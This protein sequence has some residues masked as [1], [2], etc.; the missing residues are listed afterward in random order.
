VLIIF[1]V[2]IIGILLASAPIV[3]A[4]VM[5]LMETLPR[6][7]DTTLP[8]A[9]K[10]L[11]DSKVLANSQEII[12]NL[13]NRV[14]GWVSGALGSIVAGSLAFFN[15]VSFIVVTP[16]V[17]FYLL[18]DWPLIVARVESWW[19]R[20]QLPAIKALWVESDAALSGF[21][22]GQSLVCLALAFFYAVGWSLVGLD[23]A[24]VLGLLAGILGFVPF[25]GSLNWL[26]LPI[27]VVGA[28]LGVLSKHNSGRN[29]NILVLVFGGFRLF[30][31]GGLL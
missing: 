15:L 9:E 5:Q 12:A 31:G 13:G 17:A 6:L 30:L 29:L 24:I 20:R 21:I 4:Q 2:A 23:Y 26:A 18:R 22:R 19:P 1:F 11:K 7:V 3:Q 14:V 16:I 28:V 25:L 10:M 27:A 8:L